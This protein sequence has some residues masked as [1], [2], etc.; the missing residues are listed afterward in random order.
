MAVSHTY[1]KKVGNKSVRIRLEF[2]A[3][4]DAAAEEELIGRLK[5]IYLQ[6]LEETD[7]E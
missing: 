2:P 3:Q 5:E 7:H 6:K 1:T 4:P